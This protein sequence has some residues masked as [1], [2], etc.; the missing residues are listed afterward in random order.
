VGREDEIGQKATKSS[1]VKTGLYHD[2]LLASF[3]ESGFSRIGNLDNRLVDTSWLT[4]VSSTPVM[5]N[6]ESK[7]DRSDFGIINSSKKFGI[8]K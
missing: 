6:R 2:R 1:P 8:Q 5:A 4:V 3:C 7:L